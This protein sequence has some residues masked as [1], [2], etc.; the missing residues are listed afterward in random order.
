M[1]SIQCS[2]PKDAYMVFLVKENKHFLE[3]VI[4]WLATLGESVMLLFFFFFLFFFKN[5]L[6][7]DF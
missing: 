1:M 3:E 5:E 4:L 2:F 7:V 6:M